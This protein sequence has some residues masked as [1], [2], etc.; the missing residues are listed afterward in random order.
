MLRRGALCPMAEDS[1]YCDPH[2][3]AGSKLALRSLAAAHARER[4]AHT[5]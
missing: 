1:R 3:H 2:N 4:P 5:I